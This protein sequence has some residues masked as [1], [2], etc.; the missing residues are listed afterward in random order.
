MKRVDPMVILQPLREM[1][2]LPRMNGKSKTQKGST[3]RKCLKW[4]RKNHSNAKDEA[5]DTACKVLPIASESLAPHWDFE[6]YVKN[7]FLELQRPLLARAQLF[8]RTR[9]APETFT[10]DTLL[11]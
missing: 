2:S 11:A 4:I 3:K 10:T 9:S 8:R 6:V 1:H 7:T 5:R